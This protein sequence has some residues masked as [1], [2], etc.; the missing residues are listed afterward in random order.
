MPRPTRHDSSV[1][2]TLERHREVLVQ[3]A[4][5]QQAVSEALLD[6]AEAACTTAGSRL[7]SALSVQRNLEEVRAP[8][9]AC[10][11][12]QAHRYVLSQVM[13]LSAARA[14]R[15]RRRSDLAA[16]QEQL[17]ARLKE[18]KTIERL[19]ERLRVAAAKWELHQDQSRLDR[20]GIIKSW[21]GETTWR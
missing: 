15:D 17:S 5:T 13:E 8:I 6:K 12:Q 21:T 3:E 14:A 11:L 20:L 10:D 9:A 2:R 19:R 16:A 1:L 18:L 7:E 4:R